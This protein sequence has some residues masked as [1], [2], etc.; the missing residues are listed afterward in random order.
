MK[1]WPR[2]FAGLLFGAGTVLAVACQ[3]AA[4]PDLESA[5]QSLL[6]AAVEEPTAVPAVALHVNAPRLGLTWGG[7]SG[8]AAP[9]SGI[10][11]TPEHPVRIA[12]NT[13][14]FVATA[15]LRLVEEGRLGLDDPISA[16]LPNAFV[17]WMVSDGYSPT[18]I[19]I[20]HLLTHTSGL[21]DHSDSENYVPAIVGEPMHRWTPAEQVESAIDEANREL[22]QNSRYRVE[23]RL[24][25]V[26]AL[27]TDLG[28][29]E[30]FDV[31]AEDRSLRL[32]VLAGAD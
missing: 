8:L 23:T 1:R 12:S 6:D 29:D 14:T 27:I 9:A 22:A 21:Y 18:E 17:E 30:V 26:K 10:E 25:K 28:L 2:T 3:P 16:H 4:E 32:H 19:T 15:I 7:A 24:Q 31:V 20:R 11:M 13:K 5:L